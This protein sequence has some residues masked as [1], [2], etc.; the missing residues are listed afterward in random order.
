[1]YWEEEGHIVVPRGRKRDAACQCVANM[2]FSVGCHHDYWQAREVGYQG[3]ENKE[4]I[5][6]NYRLNWS[7]PAVNI[8]A[9]SRC[10]GKGRPEK[11]ASKSNGSRQQCRAGKRKQ[12][13]VQEQE[14]REWSPVTWSFSWAKY[15]VEGDEKGSEEGESHPVDWRPGNL[16]KKF[17]H[18]C[19]QVDI[20]IVTKGMGRKR[21]GQK[22]FPRGHE[23]L[24]VVFSTA[25]IHG[26]SAWKQRKSLARPRHLRESLLGWT[27]KTGWKNCL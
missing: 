9:K 2:A 17:A 18:Y 6:S 20:I 23:N 14:A 15:R 16:P 10:P 1:M 13:W 21:N 26:H 22:R 24:E 25:A 12:C 3:P 5:K 8:W 11:H 19:E 4:C 7:L 27:V